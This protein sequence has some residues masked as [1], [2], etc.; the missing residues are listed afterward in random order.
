[1]PYTGPRLVN[2][3]EMRF[4]EKTDYIN[5]EKIREAE[6]EAMQKGDLGAIEAYSQELVFSQVL[7]E[8]EEKLGNKL[9]LKLFKLYQLS[10]EYM[11]YLQ[12]VLENTAKESEEE[13]DKLRNQCKLLEESTMKQKTKMVELKKEV[14]TKRKAVKSYDFFLREFAKLK[15][16]PLYSCKLCKG[17]TFVTKDGL[18]IHY[19]KYHL[20][21]EKEK[22]KRKKV[23]EKALTENMEKV[24]KDSLTNE[25]DKI[26]NILKGFNQK[27]IDLKEVL[28]KRTI[29]ET[30]KANED[31]KRL[32]EYKQKQDQLLMDIKNQESMMQRISEVTLS[33]ASNKNQGLLQAMLINSISIYQEEKKLSV[34]EERGSSE[35]KEVVDSKA[36]SIENEHKSKESK[37]SEETMRVV[38]GN[39]KKQPQKETKNEE[40]EEEEEEK[41]EK[42]NSEY[43]N[44]SKVSVT[45]SL[46]H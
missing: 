30:E 14:H 2:I 29:K 5:W 37:E 33:R 22:E 8:D 17:K 12:G 45:Q 24:I 25:M 4:Q 32:E 39:T 26:E 43:F 41:K 16:D 21:I 18:D 19:T 9:F 27:L 23:Q 6:I 42:G 28:D 1:M 7:E 35:K 3:P 31:A 36:E 15:T 20:Y 10:V 40:E 38:T 44:N 46:K 11:L 34:V 13:Y